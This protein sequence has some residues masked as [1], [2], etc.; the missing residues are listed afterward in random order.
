MITAEERGDR[1]AVEFE[2]SLGTLANEFAAICSGMLENRPYIFAAVMKTLLED[3]NEEAEETSLDELFGD[4]MAE[5]DELTN[6]KKGGN[7]NAK[8]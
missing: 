8:S 3:E 2:G 4:V 6:L 5:L 1:V 7:N